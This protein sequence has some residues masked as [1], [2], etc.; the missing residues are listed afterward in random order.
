M[1]QRK[2]SEVLLNKLNE[3]YADE[4]FVSEGYGYFDDLTQA[5]TF[6]FT[7]DAERI[8]ELTEQLRLCSADQLNTEVERNAAEKAAEMQIHAADRAEDRADLAEAENAR[9]REMLKEAKCYIGTDASSCHLRD[10]IEEM[11]KVRQETHVPL[12]ET[13]AW[14]EMNRLGDEIEAEAM[15]GDAEPTVQGDSGM[16]EL[17]DRFL[18]WPLPKSVCSD[19]C[20][21][22]PSYPHPRTGTNLLTAAEAEQM[23]QYVLE[24]AAQDS[25]E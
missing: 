7:R 19:T 2:R 20:V 22:D 5:I 16:K 3:A 4:T 8:A 24:Q 14:K 23:L 15:S 25:K 6:E 1:D 11:L 17:V 21:T 9:L 10:R 12:T 18:A 13:P